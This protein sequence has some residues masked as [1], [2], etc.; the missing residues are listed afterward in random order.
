MFMDWKLATRNE[1]G[2]INVPKRWLHI[3]YYEAMNILFRFENSL[4]V[5][6][7]AILKNEFLEKWRD[8]V[9][10]LPGG[11]SNSIKA[12]AAKRISQAESFGY[13]GFD[14]KAPLM[15]LTSGELVEL[16]MA[17]AYWPKFKGCFKGNKDIIK[18][19]LLEIGTIRNSLAHFRPIKPEDIELVKQNSR[20]T[21]VGV[22]EC[23]GN[24]FNQRLRV[25]TNSID[26]WYKSISTLGT[27][28]ITTAPFYSADEC[29]VNIKLK[30]DTP[31]LSKSQI[32]EKKFYS[33]TV[34]KINTSNILRKHNVLT[35]YVTYVSEDVSYPVLSEKYDLQ[36]SKDLNFV[37]RK[38]ILVENNKAIA[39]E[40]KEV[41]T[42]ITEECD[43]LRQ[44]SLARGSIIETAEGN[45]FVLE[46]EGESKWR[47]NYSGLLQAYQP[48]DPDEYWGQEQS[49]SD[50]V[51]GCSRYP[52]MP[53]DI[54]EKGGYFD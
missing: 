15:H 54:S 16:I 34:A 31:I 10:T 20:H 44:D 29:W 3:H 45:S 14:I 18:N 23:L 8:C 42:K 50:I 26:E 19:K 40:F 43:L 52:W 32:I 41:L 39:D 27:D 36:V 4:R 38:D 7:Y 51:A 30:F 28:L 53:G 12:T 24:I 21:L 13:I 46:R 22:E 47:H 33:F 1:Q 2:L 48:N 49:A 25:P 9:F 37:F 17:E 6:V 35:R 5:F 11:D